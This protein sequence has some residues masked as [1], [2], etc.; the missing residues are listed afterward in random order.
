TTWQLDAEGNTVAETRYASKITGS[1]NAGTVAYSGLLAL[2]T[3]NAAYDRTT[4]FTCDLNGRRLS[5]RRWYVD[6]STVSAAG[7][8][9]TSSQTSIISY[10]Y[11]GL[12]NVVT[13]TEADSDQTTYSYDKIGR[14]TLET[15]QSFTD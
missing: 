13:R 15:A 5:E 6:A 3:P 11:D 4:T 12:G 1:F 10:T 2:V 8:L 7:A 9:S 14:L